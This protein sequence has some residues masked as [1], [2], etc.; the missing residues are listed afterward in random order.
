MANLSSSVM[1]WPWQM[2]LSFLDQ[3]NVHVK[4]PVSLQDFRCW[5]W[6]RLNPRSISLLSGWPIAINKIRFV[7]KQ[8]IGI[9]KISERARLKIKECWN[10]ILKFQDNLCRNIGVQIEML[11]GC[12]QVERW[13]ILFPIRTDILPCWWLLGTQEIPD[14]WRDQP[15]HEQSG[16][17]GFHEW[18]Q[19]ESL[20][21][22]YFQLNFSIFNTNL[23]FICWTL[24][25]VSHNSILLIGRHWNRKSLFWWKYFVL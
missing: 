11:S 6:D 4:W 22:M 7:P 9:I 15:E 18:P 16:E 12:E 3:I 19:L 17:H 10:Y 23:L 20:L 24:P 25:L 5:H 14:Q 13:G 2:G 1:K 21:K 8:S